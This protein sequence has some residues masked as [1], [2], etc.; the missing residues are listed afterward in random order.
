MTLSGAT[1]SLPRRN[2][3]PLVLDRSNE[4]LERARTVI[5][6]VTLSMMKRP[7][8]FAPGA[9]PVF[10]SRGRGALVEDVDGNEF[11]DF[12]CG[13]GATSLGHQHPALQEAMR[14]VLERGFIHSLPVSLEVSAAELLVDTIPGA[15]MARFFK[16]GADATSAA[17]RLARAISGKERI[18]AVGYNGWHDHFMFDTPGVPKA[19][20]ALTRRM[21]LFTPEDEAPLLAAIEQDAEHLSALL[22]SV[23]YNRSLSK[24]FLASV[25]AAC[26]RHGVL[27]IFDE[28]VTGFRLALGG[29]HQHFGIQA[30][31]ACFSKSLAAGMPLSA[32][33]GPREHLKVMDSLQVSTT[34][35]G[36]L[37]SLAVCEA[38]LNVYRTTDYISQIATLGSALRAGVNAAASATN[39]PLRVLGYDSIPLFSFDREPAKH[40]PLM[41]NFQAQMAECGVLLRRDLNFINGAHTQ[42]QI[43]FTVAATAESLSAMQRAGTFEV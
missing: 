30:D 40:A 11:V 22:L 35:G 9:F 7:E 24:A 27:L 4:L 39:A 6:G 43:E 12:I 8:H 32:V 10:L 13:L 41:R 36:E 18:I 42:E 23:P 34:F 5:P 3:S 25:R 28:I 19:L 26:T 21:P 1:A 29:A 2:P 31:I 20:S 38:A 37:L 16:T 15:E 14:S 17:V 33:V